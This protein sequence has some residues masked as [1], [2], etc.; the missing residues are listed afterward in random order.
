MAS[1]ILIIVVY[2]IKAYSTNL[3]TFALLCAGFGPALITCTY[4]LSHLFK[5][6]NH[7]VLFLL[8]IYVLIGTFLPFTLM[9]LLFFQV[10]DKNWFYA[11]G[12]TF[13]FLDPY[14]TFFSANYSFIMKTI[15]PKF[16]YAPLLPGVKVTPLIAFG[17][18]MG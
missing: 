7:A 2:E 5:T 18:F 12:S 6:A 16:S 17:A 1:L 4:T 9:M 15:P 10:D 8:L 13:F 11:V 3:A 14:Y